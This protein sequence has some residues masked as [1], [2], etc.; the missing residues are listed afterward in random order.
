MKKQS[1]APYII[2]S[3]SEQHRLLSLP[4]PHHPLVSIFNFSDIKNEADEISQN[5]VLNFYCI[6]IKKNFKGKLKYGQ[7]YYDFDEGVMSFIS[8]NQL[9]SKTTGDDTPVE[10]WCLVFHPDFI[11]QYSLGKSIKNYGFFSYTL[12]E[13]LHL[14]DKE[15]KLIET[16]FQNIE[17]EY[18][19]SIDQYS[20]D[21]IVAQI[22]LLLHYSNRFYNRQFITRKK[23]NNALLIQLETILSDYFDSGQVHQLGLPSVDYISSRL[24]VSPNYLSDLLR[25]L[26]GQST[27]Q[28][29]HTKL[30]EK[31]KEFLTTT[32]LSVSEIAYDLGFQYPQSFNKFFKSKTSVS[33]LQ[34]R[35]SFN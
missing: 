8:P 25:A 18:K 31:A 24:N 20:Q 23:A 32:T 12:Y 2:Q 27:Q 17:G 28:H 6:A 5:F 14:S 9:L 30:I 16:I 4:K 3:I 19:S 35:H 22:E 15:E 13:A 11:A 10:G 33:P 1:N 29:I 26:T 21:V 34:F 7:N